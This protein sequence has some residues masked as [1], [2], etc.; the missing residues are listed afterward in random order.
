MGK[1]IDLTARAVPVRWVIQVYDTED[2]LTCRYV[3]ESDGFSEAQ[4][5]VFITAS[6]IDRVQALIEA[7]KGQLARSKAVRSAAGMRWD[8]RGKQQ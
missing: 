2:Y 8:S 1:A 5:R 6:T 4:W 7:A 3:D